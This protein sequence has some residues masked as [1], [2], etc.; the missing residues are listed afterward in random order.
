MSKYITPVITRPDLKARADCRIAVMPICADLHVIYLQVLYC[1]LGLMNEL[2]FLGVH[3]K[4]LSYI[5]Y[6]NGSVLVSI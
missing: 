4:Q 1:F 3:L 5:F 2:P 6:E